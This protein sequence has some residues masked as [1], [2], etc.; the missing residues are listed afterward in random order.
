MYQG[1]LSSGIRAEDLEAYS[2]TTGDNIEAG[3]LSDAMVQC[4]QAL[5]RGIRAAFN[6]S[7]DPQTGQGWRSRVVEGDGH[8]ILLDT[9]RLMQAAT[10]GGAGAIQDPQERSVTI[11]VRGGS[12][13]YAAVHQFDGV[14]RK[15][16]EKV[17]RPFMGAST[18]TL[19]FCGELIADA[20]LD[21]F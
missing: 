12:V 14:Q 21:W 7:V 16:G 18:E 3:K 15:S 2:K 9:G 4:R 19:D 6:S 1:T 13:P 10:G 5:H 17:R 8:P 20:G 11:G